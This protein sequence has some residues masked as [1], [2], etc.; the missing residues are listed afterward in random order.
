MLKIYVEHTQQLY[1]TLKYQLITLGSFTLNFP[2]ISFKNASSRLWSRLLIKLILNRNRLSI[3]LVELPKFSYVVFS[4]KS[5]RFF[6][7]RPRL[8]DV[9]SDFPRLNNQKR[10]N[11]PAQFQECSLNEG[12]KNVLNQKILFSI[13][14][15]DA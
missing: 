4:P 8:D 10:K 7:I 3:A 14:S 6:L 1:K 15:T 9:S 5:S 11:L 13:I 2:K 12:A